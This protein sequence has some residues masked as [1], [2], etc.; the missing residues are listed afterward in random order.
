MANQFT[1]TGIIAILAL[2]GTAICL[3]LCIISLC[4][5]MILQ[6]INKRTIQKLQVQRQS[7]MQLHFQKT[8]VNINNTNAKINESDDSKS[9][10]NTIITLTNS[11]NSNHSSINKDEPQKEM[12]MHHS[13]NQIAISKYVYMYNQNNSVNPQTPGKY[14]PYIIPGEN[15]LSN[16]QEGLPKLSNMNYYYDNNRPTSARL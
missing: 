1:R 15:V 16:K 9:I 12:E 7:E 2:S 4:I 6:R 10:H 3:L 5:V 14:L 8:A 11:S 13:G